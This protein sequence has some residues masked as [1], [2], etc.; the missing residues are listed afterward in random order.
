[1]EI[2]DQKY[3]LPAFLIISGMG[4]NI[5]K[6]SLACNIIKEFSE[7]ERITAIKISSHFHEPT[8]ELKLLFKTGGYSISKEYNPGTEKDSSKML[9]AG[10]R[11][12]FYIQSQK[13]TLRD[14]FEKYIQE[15]DPGNAVVCESS[16]LAKI[17]TPGIGFTILSGNKINNFSQSEDFLANNF[18][19]ISF[20]GKKFTLSLEKIKLQGTRWLYDL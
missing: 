12:S 1:M 14:A 19:Q 11:D 9:A 8:P 10:A 3:H 13:D 6:T 20:D 17:I 5:G 7:K 18:K 4:R 16:A 2:A 15:F